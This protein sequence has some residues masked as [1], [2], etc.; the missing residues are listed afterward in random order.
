[1]ARR[2]RELPTGREVP[3]LALSVTASPGV[4]AYALHAGCN[5]FIPKPVSD[6]RGLMERIT[7]WLRPADPRD[8][9]AQPSL[10]GNCVL[11][12]QPLPKAALRYVD[13]R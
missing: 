4:E 6:Y 7:H 3:I 11:C 10:N 8:T 13:P 12:R 1:A 2:I 9:P 5:E